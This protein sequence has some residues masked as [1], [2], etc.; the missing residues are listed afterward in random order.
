MALTNLGAM[1]GEYGLK[2]GKHLLHLSVAL[3]IV[4]L[5]LIQ[6]CTEQYGVTVDAM[7]KVAA[8]ID[9]ENNADILAQPRPD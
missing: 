4:N 6:R 5:C 3:A 2:L 9:V 8:H 1:G 7:V